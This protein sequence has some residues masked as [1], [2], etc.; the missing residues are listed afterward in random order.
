MRKIL[1]LSLLLI[2]C[3][4][5]KKLNKA[6]NTVLYNDKAFNKVGLQWA[7]LNPIDTTITN[8]II[9]S[10]TITLRDTLEFHY[11][12]EVAHTDTLFKIVQK[13]MYVHDS[14]QKY[15]QDNRVLNAY[16]DT[17]Q[18]YKNQLFITSVHLTESQQETSKYKWR[19]F[20]LLGIIVLILGISIYLK[21]II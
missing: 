7:K 19:F 6:V 1:L 11:I 14:V 21:I 3:S 12:D 16:R 15:V 18:F 9:K 13:T 17:I 5:E 8:T 4:Q 10:D 2:S 20:G